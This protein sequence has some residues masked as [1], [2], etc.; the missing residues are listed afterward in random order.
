MAKA[1]RKKH[2]PLEETSAFKAA[3]TALPETEAELL[4]L[5]DQM[6]LMFNDAALAGDET[7]LEDAATVYQAVV[8]R[9]NGNTFFGCQAEDGRSGRVL[10]ERHTSPP[11]QVPRWGQEGEF[12]VTLTNGCRVRVGFHA[13]GLSLINTL[14]L[15]AVDYDQPFPSYTG[16]R[17]YTMRM[18]DHFGRSVAE[19]V[20]LELDEYV[21]KEGMTTIVHPAPKQQPAW[22]KAALAPVADDGQLA[23]FADQPPPKR[24]GRKPTGQAMTPAQRAEAYRKRQKEKREAEGMKPVN[25]TDEERQML[26]AALALET[27]LDHN[28]RKNAPAR[29]AL[30]RRLVP[31]SNWT[32]E[33][34]KRA[35]QLMYRDNARAEATYAKGECARAQAEA[36]RQTRRA[37]E[38]ERVLRLVGATKCGEEWQGVEQLP[39]DM[40]QLLR[41]QGPVVVCLDAITR[42]RKVAEL[43]SHWEGE[44]RTLRSQAKALERDN[45]LLQ[46]ER[47]KAFGAANVF[48]E[49]LRD[50]GLSTDYRAASV[51]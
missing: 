18:A 27:A 35:E 29:L 25:L 47:N 11:G 33:G 28:C 16:Y 43:C 23:M 41:D 2:V 13:R 12:L 5:A 36:N 44:A 10:C 19:A 20:R 26:A 51:N 49:R 31:G 14:D 30:M 39:E 21:A 22:L 37:D 50:A 6:G 48:Q 34:E 9:M 3:L 45:E 42:L 46:D 7:A 40:V 4:H 38:A 15:N 32:E 1:T 8:Y 24:R 17:H